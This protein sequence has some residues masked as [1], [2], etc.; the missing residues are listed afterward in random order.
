[1]TLGMPRRGAPED[2]KRAG[3][4]TVKGACPMKSMPSIP[5]VVT[6][7]LALLAMVT[8]LPFAFAQ[9]PAGP[10]PSPTPLPTTP[11]NAPAGGGDVWLAA[12][13]LGLGVLA[14]IA[15]AAKL[16]DLRARREAE[17]LQLQAQISDELM[18]DRT[19]GGL[20]VVATAHVP[21]VKGSPATIVLTGQVPTP[22]LR[23]AAIRLVE[24]EACR[25][26][27]D[28]RLEDRVAVVPSE[29]RRAA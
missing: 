26:R 1:M 18:R 10:T 5:R 27:P 25:T 4:L 3:A 12:V 19:L 17:A 11:P 21:V 20:P 2:L 14:I 16:V 7:L 13:V 15:A 24:K 9:T 23:Q 8:L 28:V 22:E 6:F 29:A